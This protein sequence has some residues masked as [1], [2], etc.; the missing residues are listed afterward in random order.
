M[1]TRHILRAVRRALVPVVVGGAAVLVTFSASSAVTLTYSEVQINSATSVSDLVPDLIRDDTGADL[2]NG[3]AG[4][5]NRGF[6]SGGVVVK[7]VTDD[8]FARSSLVNGQLKARALLQFGN[9]VFVSGGGVPLG[10]R[11]GAASAT[12][13]FADSFRAYSGNRPYLWTS[14]ATATFRF[15]V[16]GQSTVTGTVPDPVDFSAGQP[17]DQV[18]TVLRVALYKPGTV[19]LLRQQKDFDF[20]AYPDFA[21]ALAAFHALNDQIQANFIASD[22]RYFG[23]FIAPFDQDAA[24]VLAVNPTT[25]TNVAFTFS[26]GGDFDWVAS[27][28]TNVFLDASLQSV[29]ASLDFANTIVT[30]YDGPPGTTTYSGSG[31]FPS[32]LAL[33]QAPPPNTCPQTQ[34][35]WKNNPSVWP[36][37]SLTLGD[38]TYA[39]TELL[40]ILGSP[41]GADASVILAVQL[42]AAKLNI[43]NGSN[44]APIAG[45]ITP[46]DASL[47]GL[48][49]TL[50]YNV[51]TN[52]AAGKTMTQNALTLAS[53]DKQA[54]TPSCTP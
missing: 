26:P 7:R 48:S 6:S 28:T 17:L 34:G 25:P 49:G 39:K 32:T 13:E 14:G 38:K 44:P 53:Y 41:G 52:S 4:S 15:G 18:Y 36:V 35:F 11:N 9:N 47:S 2:E 45:T 29:S 19:D 8:V 33:S 37:G 54:L 20:G 23:D 1:K 3:V 5:V 46:A 22:Y 40:K 24:H 43:A 50:P 12:A 51:K 10:A 30:A 16:T 27:L 31:L 42:I 21:T